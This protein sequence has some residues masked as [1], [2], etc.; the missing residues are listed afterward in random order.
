[1]G[2]TTRLERLHLNTRR[3]KARSG[4]EMKEVVWRQAFDEKRDEAGRQALRELEEEERAEAEMM[5]KIEARGRPRPQVEQP[6]AQVERQIS[7]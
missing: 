1:M 2:V 3:Q 6:Q 7:E 4:K 5:P